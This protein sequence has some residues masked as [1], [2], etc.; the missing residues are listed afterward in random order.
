MNSRCVATANAP[1][2]FFRSIADHGTMRRTWEDA[3]RRGVLKPNK[4]PESTGANATA[5]RTACPARCANTQRTGDAPSQ[6]H[7]VKANVRCL[8]SSDH[9][10]RHVG[11]AQKCAREMFA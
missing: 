11:G 7:H 3:R 1:Q 4:C 2:A 8:L 9:V 6:R 5:M 10:K